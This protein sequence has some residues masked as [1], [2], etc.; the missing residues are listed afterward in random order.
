MTPHT[1]T[2]VLFPGQG[3]QQLGMGRDLA[4]AQ[5]DVMTLWKKAE[6]VSGLPLREIYW[7]GDAAAMADTRNL[8]PALTVVNIALWMQCAGT[9][10]PMAA[11]GHSLGEYAA[12]AASE[13]LPVADI[14]ELVVLRGR[15]MAEAD[16]QGN[17]AMA[18]I[19]KLP[20]AS[21]E[22]IARQ[23]ADATGELL[24]VA[25]YNTPEQF[26]LSGTQ[27]AVADAT[28]RVKTHK[29]RAISL[30][31]TGAFH[32]PMMQ[33]AATELASVIKKCHWNTP[34]FP[35]YCNVSG[36]AASDAESLRN[37]L[38]DQMAS[39]VRWIETI[40]NQWN[41]GVRQWIELGPKNVLGK[42]L[43]PILLHAGAQNDAWSTRTLSTGED[44]QEI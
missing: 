17:G 25:N 31:V 2:A 32:S 39:S 5:R 3:A 4:E 10:T 43:A 9:M 11:A 24:L 40:T 36:Q 27:T 16:P 28:S 22:D 30:A 35:V 37:A 15:L 38:L 13:A 21:V 42:M 33:E 7:D 34:R 20:L 23:S 19:L 12:I 14:I 29:G 18:A 8:Q 41:A 26:V 1:H 44:V 6:A